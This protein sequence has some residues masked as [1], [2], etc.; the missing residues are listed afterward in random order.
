M[1]QERRSATY[2]EARYDLFTNL[3]DANEGEVDS[4]AKLTD[5]EL[6]GESMRP[7]ALR[8]IGRRT[9]RASRK[10]LHLPGGGV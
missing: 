5:S 9:E 10:R 7:C 6:L 8:D 4:K 3:L 1:V 2:K